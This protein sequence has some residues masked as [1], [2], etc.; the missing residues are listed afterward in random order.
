MSS[1][2]TNAP[3]NGALAGVET[4]R[5]D[6]AVAIEDIESRAQHDLARNEWRARIFS[7]VS[8]LALLIVVLWFYFGYSALFTLHDENGWSYARAEEFLCQQAS[9]ALL[10]PQASETEQAALPHSPSSVTAP[11]IAAVQ[12]EHKSSPANG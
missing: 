10:R 4:A 11:A 7:V 2:D 9:R 8:P 5:S 12:T 3:G 1:I 6:T